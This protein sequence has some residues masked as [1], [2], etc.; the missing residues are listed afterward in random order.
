VAVQLGKGRLCSLRDGPPHRDGAG[1]LNGWV[2]NVTVPA[3]TLPVLSW[4]ALTIAS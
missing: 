4:R 2:K 3:P 1:S